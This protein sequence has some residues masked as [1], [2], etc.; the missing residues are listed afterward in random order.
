MGGGVLSQ[1]EK[2][3]LAPTESPEPDPTPLGPVASWEAGWLLKTAV[4]PFPTMQ[5][6]VMLVAFSAFTALL[7]ASPSPGDVLP[8]S[9]LPVTVSMA[10]LYTPPPESLPNYRR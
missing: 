1:P 8:S 9:A 6:P 5:L 10:K 2:S 4:S 3:T 7:M